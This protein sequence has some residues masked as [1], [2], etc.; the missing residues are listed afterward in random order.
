MLSG[1]RC[2]ELLSF[3]QALVR[4]PS[5]SGSEDNIAKLIA[6]VARTLG[7]DK[8]YVDSYGNVLLHMR[9]APEGKKLLFHSQMDHVSPGKHT[10]W[11]FYPYGGQIT[12][13]RLYGSG[14]SDQ[15]GALAAMIQAGAYLKEA[16]IK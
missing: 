9:F 12:N 1:Q 4:T 6:N 11:S 2:D 14:V 16:L 10:E 5:L 15:K 3:C 13:K 8:I 7:Y